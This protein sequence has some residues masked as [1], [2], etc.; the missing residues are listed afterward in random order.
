MP[1]PPLPES[2]PLTTPPPPS[3]SPDLAGGCKVLPAPPWPFVQ[4]PPASLATPAAR[5]APAPAALL[6]GSPFPTFRP[7]HLLGLK[8]SSDAPPPAG[9][10][11]PT[12]LPRLCYP[13]SVSEELLPQSR[14][15]LGAGPWCPNAGTAPPVTRTP[16][17]GP[18]GPLQPAWLLAPGWG[19]QVWVE[20]AKKMLVPCAHQ[21]PRGSSLRASSEPN[22]LRRSRLLMPSHWRVGLPPVTVGGHSSFHKGPL[23][24]RPRP[25][26]LDRPE[27][28]AQHEVGGC[29]KALRSTE[30]PA[31]RAGGPGLAPRPQGHHQ[32]P[33]CHRQEPQ[34]S[35]P[36][37]VWPLPAF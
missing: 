14:A 37:L 20:A 21:S 10:P 27:A 2:Q 16:V 30:F 6:A 24:G 4:A 32:R 29:P 31:G 1:P 7:S 12:L 9:T 28:Q 11:V 26:A 33:Q 36:S 18:V 19:E 22:Y 35:L 17:A 8:A 23:L 25:A 15:S 13:G 34:Q 5:L 3:E